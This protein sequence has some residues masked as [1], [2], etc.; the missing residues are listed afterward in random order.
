MCSYPISLRVP[1]R[2]NIP[3]RL[4]FVRDCDLPQSLTALLM[5]IPLACVVLDPAS[6]PAGH[7]AERTPLGYTVE[8]DQQP[9]VER[10]EKSAE[11]GIIRRPLSGLFD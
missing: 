10:I 11:P 1:G 9:G 6:G 7:V 8:A 2:F 5:R 3:P 4:G